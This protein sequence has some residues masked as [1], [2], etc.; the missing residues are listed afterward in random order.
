MYFSNVIFISTLNPCTHE[1]YHV[2]YSQFI[3]FYLS[4]VS[5]IYSNNYNFQVAAST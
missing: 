5:L 4:V 3:Y 1:V 2:T